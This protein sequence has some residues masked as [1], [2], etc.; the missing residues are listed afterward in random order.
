M[1]SNFIPNKT[2][3]TDNKGYPSFNSKVRNLIDRKNKVIQKA[4]KMNQ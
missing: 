2:V 4:P 1:I 3:I